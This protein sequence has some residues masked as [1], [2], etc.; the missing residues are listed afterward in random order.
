[1][2]ELWSDNSGLEKLLLKA[3]NSETFLL[4]EQ[5]SLFFGTQLF[6]SR[7]GSWTEGRPGYEPAPTAH[8]LQI[9]VSLRYGT[10]KN[11]GLD[12]RILFKI[13]LDSLL[14]DLE[15]FSSKIMN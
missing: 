10:A 8:K 1:M 15:L 5:N 13:D 12:S 4:T 6:L 3:V 14:F 2:S 11:D 9:L 7:L